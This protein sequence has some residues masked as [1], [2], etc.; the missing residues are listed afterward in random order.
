MSFDKSSSSNNLTISE[1]MHV[2]AQI[3]MLTR[4]CNNKWREHALLQ[5][6][7]I[8]L[9]KQCTLS[10]SFSI[11]VTREY[12]GKYANLKTIMKK[13]NDEQQHNTALTTSTVLQ[14]C[15]RLKEQIDAIQHQVTA[16]QPHIGPS[17]LVKLPPIS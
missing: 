10:R 16:L 1:M 5:A 2:Q 14:E 7:I 4:K 15:Y 11:R 8:A 12:R 17:K 3:T 6:K 9:E 13:Q